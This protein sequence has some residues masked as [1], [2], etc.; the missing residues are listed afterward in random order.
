ME[1]FCC[2]SRWMQV[3]QN[4]IVFISAKIATFL[5]L[6]MYCMNNGALLWLNSPDSFHRSVLKHSLKNAF[7]KYAYSVRE[8]VC[9]ISSIQSHLFNIQIP[10]GPKLL[11][12]AWYYQSCF[13]WRHWTESTQRRSRRFW[14]QLSLELF[15]VD[16]SCSP[17]LFVPPWVSS[18]LLTIPAGD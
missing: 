7:P 2:L 16:F 12:S 10:Y 5:F 1:R 15:E 3:R 13:D 9:E 6:E 17:S 11:L 8:Q 14:V 18:Q 4:D